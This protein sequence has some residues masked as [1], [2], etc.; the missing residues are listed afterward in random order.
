M[1]YE[2]NPNYLGEV[3]GKL[4]EDE[5]VGSQIGVS[6]RQQERKGDCIPDGLIV[7]MP[8]TIYIETKNYDWFYDDQLERHLRELQKAPGIKILVALANF[9]SIDKRRFARIEATTREQDGGQIYFFA[10]TFEDLVSATQIDS[11]PK[12]VQDARADFI[13]Y[14]NEEE[15]LPSWQRWIDIVSCSTLPDEVLEG[16]AYLCPTTGGAY[17]HGRCKF[18]GMYREKRVEK[19]AQ[20]KAMVEVD[21]ES[22]S[23]LR[24]N[25]VEDADQ[26]LVETAILA[27]RR[28]RPD[29]GP[30]RVLVLDRLYDT[31]FVKDSPGGVRTKTYM[32]VSGLDVTSAPELA[33]ALDG[34]KWSQI[35]RD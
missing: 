32:D 30:T 34:K 13:A 26:E 22:E 17:N 20:I 3:L 2:K 33:L 18:F 6:F 4:C 14:L 25:N 10:R 35:A 23:V 7:Q 24:W 21:L 1:I 9:E 27:V 15:L 29:A 8:V 16:N 11:L 28:W 12:D 5:N 31:N 19:V